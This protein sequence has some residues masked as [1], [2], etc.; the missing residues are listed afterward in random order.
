MKRP[1]LGA[2]L[3]MGALGSLSTALPAWAADDCADGLNRLGQRIAAFE[4]IA[5]AAQVPGKPAPVTPQEIAQLRAL[6]QTAQRVAQTANASACMA[7]LGEADALQGAIEHPRAVAADDLTKAKLRG[8]DGADL[9]KIAELVID[10]ATGRV[11]YAVVEMGGFLGIGDAHVPVPWALFQ[12]AADHDGYVLNVGKERLSGAPRFAGTSRPDMGDRQWAMAVHT[13]Y[14]VPPYWMRDSATLAVA[15]GTVAAAA[16]PAQLQQEVQRLSQEVNK[17]AADR[18]QE[19]VA[20]QIPTHQ[21][22][23]TVGSAGSTGSTSSADTPAGQ[24]TASQSNGVEGASQ[25][26]SDH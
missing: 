5:P 25:P 21:V 3:L 20:Q 23:V 18:P 17:L 19:P 9:G 14:G 13:Y 22:P 7:I 11:A 2:A 12:P 4:A 16:A 6:Q 8:G 15:G 24:T 26:A 10:P 1:L